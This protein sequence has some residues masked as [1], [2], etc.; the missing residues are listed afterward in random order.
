[1]SGVGAPVG[2][3]VR[4]VL[5]EHAAASSRRARVERAVVEVVMG[6]ASD[7]VSGMEDARAVEW[8]MS[9]TGATGP[10][11]CD[12]LRRRYARAYG[13][14]RDHALRRHSTRGAIAHPDCP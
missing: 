10:E 7:G 6:V 12:G 4:G 5:V 9:P 1:M 14:K 11:V 3:P 2:D 8:L 13:M